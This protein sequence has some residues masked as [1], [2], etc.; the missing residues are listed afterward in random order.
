MLTSKLGERPYRMWFSD[1]TVTCDEERV[2]I[3]TATP[4]A[5]R[6]I[7]QRFAA[8][9]DD[10]AAEVA[11]RAIPVEVRA[12]E[13][14]SQ[15]AEPLERGVPVQSDVVTRVRRRPPL[16]DFDAFIV[17]QCNRLACAAA[18]RL[19]E[20]DGG[21]ISPLF[22]HGA[23]G[24]GKTHL[25][26]A[27]CRRAGEGSSLRVRYVTAEQFTNEFIAS[28]RSG[29]FHRFRMRYRHVD[30]LAIDDVHFVA[31]KT[32]T[33]DE[34]LHTLDAAGLR[35]AR[36][37][38]ASNEDPR[39][40]RRLNRPLCNRLIAGMVVEIERPDR[41]TRSALVEQMV[42]RRGLSLTAAAIERLAG[43][44]MGS[45]REVEGAV[46][47]LMAAVTLLPDASP[48]AIGIEVVER[49]LRA[50]PPSM[51]PVPMAT[52]IDVVCRRLGVDERDL[53]GKTRSAPVVLARSLA[54]WLGRSLTSLS[55]P[56]LARGL[57]RGHH[58]TIHAAVGR[59]ERQLAERGTI[60]VGDRSVSLREMVD[61][62][63]WEARSRATEREQGTRRS[64][65]KVAG[66][67]QAAR[68]IHL[69]HA[70]SSCFSV[71]G[72]FGYGIASCGVV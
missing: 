55:Y 70:K 26:Q 15:R 8:V 23:C 35:G 43:E 63:A 12:G 13:S 36:L 4:L 67:G 19:A 22:L 46:T 50:S 49:V 64:G 68:G 20:P 27:I 41:Q 2:S 44:S 30:L 48:G 1:T 45:V 60:R 66:G 21:G 33:Q 29:D 53:R 38:L 40:I 10:V 5:A 11:G 24:V 56:E 58:S 57:G 9:M 34:L 59:I 71:C 7:H 31:N 72:W 69:R 6:W 14:S 51:V 28:S 42:G 54:S 18:A 61:Q 32:R 37:A 62:L 16:L 52:I 25:L 17:G 3:T 65:R 47:R 39:Q